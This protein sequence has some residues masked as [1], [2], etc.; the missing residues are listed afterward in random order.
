MDAHTGNIVAT[1]D[2]VGGSDEVWYDGKSGNYYLAAAKNPGGPVLGVIDATSN[3]WV[4]NL[5]SGPRAHS[6]AADPKTG[7]VFVPIEA[8]KGSADCAA[9]CI[10]VY[11]PQGQ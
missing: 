1:I 6:V 8:H 2:K 5:P 11:A 7:K 9:G 10:A 4:A 3:R